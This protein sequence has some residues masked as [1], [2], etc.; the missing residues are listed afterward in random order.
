[1]IAEV[2]LAVMIA[3]GAALL[4]RSVGNLYAVDPGVR[5][6]GVA[7]VDVMLG[8]ASI[9]CAREQTLDELTTALAELPGVRSVG[10]VQ[11][12]AAARWRLQHATPR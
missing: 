12:L 3:A 4:A 10:V 8:G 2:A 6:E 9:A 1:M 5:T 7:V 11:T